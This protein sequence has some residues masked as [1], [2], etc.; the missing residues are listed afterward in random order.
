MTAM[1]WNLLDWFDSKRAKAQK[2]EIVRL[3]SD[4]ARVV[5]EADVAAEQ[6]RKTL[7]RVRTSLG[8]SGL[9]DGLA[10][11]PSGCECGTDDPK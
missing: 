10:W 1:T 5:D 9:A 8:F 7:K 3:R 11:K 6:L 2:R 4:V